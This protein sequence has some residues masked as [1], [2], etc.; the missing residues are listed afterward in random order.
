MKKFRDIQ[1]PF[2][3]EKRAMPDP[4]ALLG[5]LL[6]H[7]AVREFAEQHP[8]IPTG[9]Y[10]RCLT[11]LSQV[12][13]ER[14]HCDSCPG[15]EQCPNSAQGHY[16][17]LIAV[18]EAISLQMA[19]CSKL[20]MHKEEQRR[21]SLIRSHHIPV[22]IRGATFES[23]DLN[24]QRE[25]AISAAI[26]FCLSFENGIPDKGLYLYGPFGVGKSYIAGA[27]TNQLAGIGIPSIMVHLPALVEEMKSAISE[28]SVSEKV[29]ALK[30]TPVLILDDIGAETLTPWIRDDILSVV[31]QYRMTEKLPTIY[32]SNLNLDEL[33]EHFAHTSKGGWDILRAKRIMER[34]RPFVRAIPV[35]GRN[36]RYD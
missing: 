9:A 23:I 2:H 20:R 26:D 35:E 11:L 8:E 13:T 5:T 3:R 15:L 6:R 1:M 19:E 32:T 22:E 21:R 7:P 28:N 14:S 4:D 30:T 10:R 18:G 31:F 17:M 36:R 25:E 29:E 34:I 33:E 24:A 16:P 12:V 27:I